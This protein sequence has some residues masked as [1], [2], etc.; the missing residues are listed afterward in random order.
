MRLI[1]Y[2][3]FFLSAVSISLP[4]HSNAQNSVVLINA[5]SL[6]GVV[7]DGKDVSLVIG[8]VHYYIPDKNLDI[9][10]DT[11][12]VYRQEE[13]YI[14]RGNVKVIDNEKSF[15]SDLL[16]YNA[17][18][19]ELHS[20][21]RF[22]YT[23]FATNRNL[24]ADTGTYYYENNNLYAIG[25]VVY[26]DSLRI[27][28]ADTLDFLD[29]GFEVIPRGNVRY[30]DFEQNAVVTSQSGYFRNDEN[31]GFMS[32]KPRLAVADSA[33]ADSLIIAGELMRYFGGDS[34]K[35]IVT[36]S[37]VIQKGELFAESR[38]ATYDVAASMVYLRH[39]PKIKRRDTEIFGSEIDLILVENE[40]TEI[41]VRD[42][43]YVLTDADTSGT[44]D[45]KNVIRGKTIT[46]HFAN[47]EIYKIVAIQNAES[48]YYD[49][50]DTE[51]RGKSVSLSGQIVILI[52]DGKVTSINL[53]NGALQNFIPKNMLPGLIKKKKNE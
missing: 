43:A 7:Q 44:Y 3:L 16:T 42:S 50:D 10:C 28:F 11:T 22:T 2:T 34:A 36:D 17:L 24:T 30:E 39:N 51:L 26:T 18:T 52:D 33:N 5:E 8:E 4:R 15:I 37:V 32:G 20:P 12:Y 53:S 27:L 13:I 1:S 9:F 45:L 19:E 41:V 31:F 6:R 40:L 46:I 29:E 49:F 38:L 47:E 35:F 48:E 21:G 14:L 25:N 23:E